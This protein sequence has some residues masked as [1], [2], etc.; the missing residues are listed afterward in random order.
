VIF[1][2]PRGDAAERGSEYKY[3]AEKSFLFNHQ[4]LRARTEC[5]HAAPK[6][7]QDNSLITVER[8]RSGV[9]AD[10]ATLDL[11]ARRLINE[12]DAEKAAEVAI[13]SRLEVV[14]VR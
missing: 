1:S 2:L 10:H 14:L 9:S 4:V 6:L 7:R 8:P 13:Q 11:A 5:F 3:G 12:S